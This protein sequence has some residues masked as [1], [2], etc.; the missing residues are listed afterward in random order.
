MPFWLF[1]VMLKIGDTAPLSHLDFTVYN[2]TYGK[3]ITCYSMNISL[4]NET[5]GEPE[6]VHVT[7]IERF[8]RMRIRTC[9]FSRF[10]WFR[11][12]GNCKSN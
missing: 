10:C 1:T 12:F 5:L 11:W 4:Y 8:A 3:L 2:K 9:R 6:K 7:E